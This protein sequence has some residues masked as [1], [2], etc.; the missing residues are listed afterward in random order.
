MSNFYSE[1]PVVFSSVSAV[2]ATRGS[3]DPQIGARMVHSSKEYVY[4]Y[5]A[6]ASDIYPRYGVAPKTACTSY[7]G[8]LSSAAYG[9]LFGVVVHTTIPAASYGWVCYRGVVPL[10]T[11]SA[12]IAVKAFVCVDADGTFSTYVCGTTGKEIGQVTV[13]GAAGT[14]TAYINL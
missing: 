3:N 14:I 4:I 11:T 7:S 6:G 2:T 1:A 8:T 9:K 12:S 5:N 10:A 13:A